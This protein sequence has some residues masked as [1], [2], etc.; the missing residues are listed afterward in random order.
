MKRP[1]IAGNW[2]M[3]LDRA[4]AVALAKGV[5]QRSAEFGTVD[6]AVCPPSDY[7]KADNKNVA[8]SPIRDAAKKIK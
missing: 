2:K 1:F 5:A 4:E 7:Q 3:N 8:G 6:V